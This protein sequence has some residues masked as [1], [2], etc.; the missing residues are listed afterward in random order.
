MNSITKKIMIYSLAG[1][2]QLGLGAAVIEASPLHHRDNSQQIVPL[3]VK[4]YHHELRQRHIERA[5]RY[6][7]RIYQENEQHQWEM[8]QRKN[9]TEDSWHDRQ[10]RENWRHDDA[11]RTIDA[12]LIG[13]AMSLA[14]N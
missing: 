13:P 5:R 8:L 3:N 1:I 14:I 4:H 9:E 12:V 6:N 7:E 2:M 11:L 10:Q